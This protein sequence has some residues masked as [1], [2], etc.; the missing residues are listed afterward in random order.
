[1]G[2]RVQT[3]NEDALVEKATQRMQKTL[4]DQR[5]A[6][7]LEQQKAQVDEVARTT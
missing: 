1:M 4:D 3:F 7:E 2:C 5:K 6:Y